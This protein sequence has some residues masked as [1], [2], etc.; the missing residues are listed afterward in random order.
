MKQTMRTLIAVLALTLTVSM[1]WGPPA[2]AAVDYNVGDRVDVSLWSDGKW[3]P[4]VV[5][6]EN[7]Q[8]YLVRVDPV[9]AGASSAEYTVPKTASYEA[10]IRRSSV[11]LP[12]SQK[13]NTS[14]PTGILDCPYES[15]IDTAKLKKATLLA[16]IRCLY[17]YKGGVATDGLGNDSRFDILSAKVGRSRPWRVNIDI[18]SGDLDTRIYPVKAKWKQTWWSD[19]QVITKTGTSI[20]GCFY[21]TLDEWECGLNQRVSDTPFAYQP[22]G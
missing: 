19:T 16:L 22:R 8:S 15:G 5:T 9:S 21:S 7:D 20:F 2:A 12:S 4:G 1:A 6:A 13:V 10:L 18:G 11:P 14:Q 3:Y 17:E